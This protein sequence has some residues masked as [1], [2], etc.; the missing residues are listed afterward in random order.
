[1][2]GDILSMDVAKAAN[3]NALPTEDEFAR[4]LLILPDE[5]KFVPFYPQH[6]PVENAE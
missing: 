2:L 3:A 5:N 1:M 4:I 6:V